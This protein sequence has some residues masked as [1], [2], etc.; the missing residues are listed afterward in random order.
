MAG[1]IMEAAK[2]KSDQLNSDDL[3][4]IDS[5]IIKVISVEVKLGKDQPVT[6]NAEHLDG[7]KMLPFKPCKNMMRCMAQGWGDDEKIY[8][9]KYLKLFRD[10]KV[11]WAGQEVGGLRIKAMSNIKHSFKF[12]YRKARGAMEPMQID[13]LDPS[14][15]GAVK[16]I[17]PAVKAAGDA[18]AAGGVKSYTEWKDGL[19]PEVKE[20]I[21]PYHPDWAKLA[22]E[23][24]QPK[25]QQPAATDAPPI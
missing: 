2:P 16:P 15:L 11:T 17:D 4:G 23:A 24:D 18:A 22:K 5:I 14:E 1:L 6:V 9:G 10:P 8:A 20:T 3:I 25:E 12:I 21:K 7:R 13:R 19:T